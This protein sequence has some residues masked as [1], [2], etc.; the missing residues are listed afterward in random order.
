MDHCGH[1]L[2]PYR[3]IKHTGPLSYPPPPTNNSFTVFGL[4][5]GESAYVLAIDD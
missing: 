2:Y 3:N 4:E 5:S 1:T